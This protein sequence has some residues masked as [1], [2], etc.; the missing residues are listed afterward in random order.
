MRVSLRLLRFSVGCLGLL[1][2]GSAWAQ[3]PQ[4]V[5][6]GGTPQHS[7]ALATLAIPQVIGVNVGHNFVLDFNSGTKCWGTTGNG[8]F[9]QGA[10]GTTT[11]TFAV[12]ATSIPSSQNVVCPSAGALPDVGM[13]QVLSTLSTTIHM[14]V[15][16]TDGGSGGQATTLTGLI[17]D[18]FS[19]TRLQLVI[20]GGD[21][22]GGGTKV[23][24][25]S[26]LASGATG[27]DVSAIPK[28]GWSAC[29]QTLQLT[30]AS[31]TSVAA[32]TAT[33]ILTYTM[34]SP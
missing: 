4:G 5:L 16:I 18:I 26:L 25:Y 29:E 15:G 34:I 10:S 27:T 24:P 21:T 33:G 28:T 1:L 9:P 8:S 13:V 20:P 19:A 22:C 30:L 32:G 17:P 14:T 3:F 7:A 31:T 12:S 23:S 6:S 11:Y 2:A